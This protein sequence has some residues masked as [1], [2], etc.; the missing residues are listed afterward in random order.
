MTP[1]SMTPNNDQHTTEDISIVKETYICRLHCTFYKPIVLNFDRGN[2]GRFDVL[3]IKYFN[4]KIYAT[5]D[6]QK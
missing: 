3:I 4:H 6:M 1:D 5:M 2:Y